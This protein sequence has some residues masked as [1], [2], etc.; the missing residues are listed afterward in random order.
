MPTKWGFTWILVGLGP[1]PPLGGTTGQAGSMALTC[2][3]LLSRF[4]LDSF[5]GEYVAS[6]ECSP[7]ILMSMFYLLV[8]LMDLDVREDVVPLPPGG[9]ELVQQGPDLKVVQY[10]TGVQN[11][12]LLDRTGVC[13]EPLDVSGTSLLFFSFSFAQNAYFSLEKTKKLPL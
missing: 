5:R 6:A 10:S 1:A 3:T 7:L 8:E 12:L 13:K 11:W 9:A 2:N 4:S